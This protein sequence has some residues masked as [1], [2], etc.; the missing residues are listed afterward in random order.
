MATDRD[1]SRAGM[2]GPLGSVLA[3]AVFPG[4]VTGSRERAFN[5]SA[6]PQ[7]RYKVETSSND[8]LTEPVRG[9]P[10]SVT[11]IPKEVLADTGATSLRDVARDQD[12]GILLGATAGP[13]QHRAQNVVGSRSGN[14]NAGGRARQDRPAIPDF[15]RR[16]PVRA[17]R[18]PRRRWT[19]P[20]PRIECGPLRRRPRK[21]RNRASASDGPDGAAR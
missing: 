2:A 9:T 10:R 15:K 8:K 16:T 19:V 7:A 18:N 14:A 20:A 4:V 17:R 5:P 3:L 1:L 12:C 13:R 21:P 11:I 6:N